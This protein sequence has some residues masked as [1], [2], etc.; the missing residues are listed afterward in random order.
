MMRGC[1]FRFFVLSVASLLSNILLFPYLIPLVCGQDFQ[2]RAEAEYLAGKN[3]S[4]LP[5]YVLDGDRRTWWTP[6]GEESEGRHS[7]LKLIFDSPATLKGF[8][9]MSGSRHPDYPGYGNLFF[10]NNRVAEAKL[11]LK[12]EQDSTII[13]FGLPDLDAEIFLELGEMQE[14][15][16]AVLHILDIHKGSK[17]NDLAISE[18]RPVANVSEG[19][20]LCRIHEVVEIS[21]HD[22]LTAEFTYWKSRLE[23]HIHVNDGWRSV[24]WGKLNLEVSGEKF[25]PFQFNQGLA[26]SSFSDINPPEDLVPLDQN[27]ERD[28]IGFGDIALIAKVTS[29][30]TV[31][32]SLPYWIDGTCAGGNS[33]LQIRGD[34]TLINAFSFSGSCSDPRILDDKL[35]F[36]NTIVDLLDGSERYFDTELG[37]AELIGGEWVGQDHYALFFTLSPGDPNIFLYNFPQGNLLHS[38]SCDCVEYGM[39][40]CPWSE[41][42]SQTNTWKISSEPE[43]RSLFIQL[44]NPSEY[45][46][47]EW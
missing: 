41:W 6:G 26:F 21:H 10:L 34:G 25:S 3:E 23:Y 43:H 36:D 30:Q 31:V 46:V 40:E 13:Y 45:R 33:L 16:S 29:N 9:I 24:L 42:D 19:A 35:Y 22:E 14:V 15:N 8:S 4:Y 17:W 32:V 37:T 5:E 12:H 47:E 38:Y 1:I 18:F 27:E 20:R 11:T 2:V 7:E 28:H 44:E 39:Y